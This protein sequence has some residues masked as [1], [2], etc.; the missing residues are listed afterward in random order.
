MGMLPPMTKVLSSI[1]LRSSV[2][3]LKGARNRLIGEL[4]AERYKR[5]GASIGEDVFIGSGSNF[6]PSHC[7]LITI[8]DEVTIAPKVTILAHDASLKR[9]IGYTRV[10]PVVIERRA[11]IGT[12]TVVMPGVRIG[13]GAV[14]GAGSVV[15]KDVAAGIV[16]AGSP[17]RPICTVEELTQKWEARRSSALT[18]DASWTVG[19]GI[20]IEKKLEMGRLLAD[21]EAWVV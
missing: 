11:F 21:S 3:V 17:A 15:T 20:N 10:A 18:L 19:G 2:K 8:E 16:V 14:V 7:W 13:Q 9:T 12:C 4:G 1:R 5:L 6:D